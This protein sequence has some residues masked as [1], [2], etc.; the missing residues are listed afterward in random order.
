MNKVELI[1]RLTRDPQLVERSGKNVCDMR[2]A[3]NDGGKTPLFIDLVAFGEQAEASAAE[4]EK[5]SQVEAKGVAPLLGVGRRSRRQSQSRE[6]LQAFGD[7]PRAGRRVAASAETSPES[8]APMAPG[9]F[10]ELSRR[11]RKERLGDMPG[12]K[13]T[14]HISNR[15]LEILDF[16]A[17]FGVVAAGRRRDLGGHR[18]HS[19]D[20]PRDPTAQGGV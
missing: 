1:G 10:C 4:F 7:R 17:R 11:A 9:S 18:P 16:I 3:V 12:G 5:G 6:A 8:P 19:D 15:D 20:R 2:L 13:R 14:D